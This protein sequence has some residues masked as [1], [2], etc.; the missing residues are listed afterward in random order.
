MQCLVQTPIF[1]PTE[2][3]FSV[4]SEETGGT[5]RKSLNKHGDI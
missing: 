4:K 2:E 5:E 1:P 3:P